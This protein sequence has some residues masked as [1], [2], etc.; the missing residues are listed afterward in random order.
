MNDKRHFTNPY[1]PFL[2]PELKKYY[3]DNGRAPVISG[4]TKGIKCTETWRTKLLQYIDIKLNELSAGTQRRY[5]RADPSIYVGYAGVAMLYIRLSEALDNGKKELYLKT[6]WNYLSISLTMIS[7]T[8]RH[9]DVTFL[10][11]DAGIYALAAVV[12][13]KLG[14]E[15]QSKDLIEQLQALHVHCDDRSLPD[16]LLYGRS[17]YLH[18]LKFVQLHLGKDAIKQEIIDK[19]VNAI[20]MSG[21]NFSRGIKS[22]SPLMF[23]W[24][25]DLYFG[26]AHG[27]SGI[28]YMLLKVGNYPA[29]IDESRD[30]LVHWCHGAPGVI[31]TFAAAY[32]AFNHTPFLDAA[33]VC[34]ST[35]WERGLLHKGHGL[36]HGVAGNAYAFLCLYRLTKDPIH[37]YRATRFAEWC[38]DSTNHHARVADSP[39]SLM[40]GLAG[41]LCFLLDML[42]V[43]K[44]ALPAFEL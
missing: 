38:M 19:V 23:T 27:L 13:H 3:D 33:I 40:E 11:G 36:C 2:L 37:L 8:R 6:A 7:N 31:Y 43:K 14:V 30:Y 28:L 25:N 44:S 42:N 20:I 9:K 34:G 15:Q 1:P 24:Y 18:S 29:T 10:C 16:E 4:T 26:A 21:K 5:Q 39:Y 12:C 22:R 17:G 32:Q 41:T 35:I